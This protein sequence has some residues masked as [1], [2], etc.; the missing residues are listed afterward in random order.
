VSTP[1]RSASSQ[2]VR[3]SRTARIR[4]W[5]AFWAHWLRSISQSSCGFT[6]VIRPNEKGGTKRPAASAASAMASLNA[7]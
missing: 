7:W 4:V 3:F 1:S 6:H 2:P 5:L